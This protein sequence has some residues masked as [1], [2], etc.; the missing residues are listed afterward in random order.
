MS[1]NSELGR[2]LSLTQF[3]SIS[4]G[5]AIGV[6]WIMLMGVWLAKSGSFGA[7]LAF[8]IGGLAVGWVALG[9]LE[10]ATA[11]PKPGGEMIF[12][13]MVFGPRVGFVVGWFLAA[14]NVAISAFESI[15]IGW[16]VST[17][18]PLSDGHVIY[19]ILGED[20]YLLRVVIGLCF[21]VLMGWLN[22]RGAVFAASAQNIFVVL[23]LAAAIV[24]IFTGLFKGDVANLIPK[25]G[26]TTTKDAIVGVVSMLAI[27][28]FFTLGF[29]YAL[30]GIA[31]RAS[32]VK[33][34]SI[35]H[36][37]MLSILAIVVFYALVIIAA[38]MS[39]PREII[40]SADLPTAAAFRAL[41]GDGFLGKVVLIAGLFG[42]LTTWNAVLFAASRI[43]FELSAMGLL[44][45]VFCKVHPKYGSPH[46]AAIFVT[47]ASLPGVFL[48]SAALSPIVGA[49]SICA[50]FALFVTCLAVYARKS[51]TDSVTSQF[52]MPGGSSGRA[53]TVVIGALLL[54]IAIFE[55]FVDG[56]DFY[57]PLTW[58]IVIVWGAFGWW[59]WK[60]H[61]SEN[62]N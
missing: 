49:A 54:L 5:A 26:G 15:S 27:A 11:I 53:M 6:G 14:G 13:F 7:V 34:K 59:L 30:Q 24:F 57:F 45:A 4:F 39:A 55:P 51:D 20:V 19:S 31:E 17:I 43:V 10:L 62:Q 28:P 44:P 47:M 16:L 52:H 38:A 60:P 1:S 33:L 36:V 23:F 41:L 21:L 9:Y 46:I 32:D 22:Y 2:S 61:K 42:L 58:I 8:L 50:M 12:T 56:S 40:L 37:I 29:N 3:F 25:F 18:V 48:S 35:A